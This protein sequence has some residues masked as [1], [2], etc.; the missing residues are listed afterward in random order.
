M[1][2]LV[3]AIALGVGARIVMR[4]ISWVSGLPG[5]FSAGGSFEVVLF[6]A[7][8]GFPIALGFF[9][10]RDRVRAR[11]PWPG[12]LLGASLF[13]VLALLPPGSAR[14][15]MAGT[16]DPPVVTALL[17]LGLCLLFGA[18][19]EWRWMSWRRRFTNP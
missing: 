17:F 7:L 18:G 1:A 3:A 14:S 13:L 19:L 12:L 10:V 15:A 2:S 16:P 5:A 8:I 4:I 6:G 11:L 9:W